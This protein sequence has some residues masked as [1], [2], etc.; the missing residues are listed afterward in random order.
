[1]SG[2]L[3]F[4]TG[5]AHITV[6]HTKPLPVHA[7]L[8]VPLAAAC[9]RRPR[10]ATCRGAARRTKPYPLHSFPL[11][12]ALHE[13]PPVCPHR[14]AP[15]K[16]HRSPPALNFPPPCPISPHTAPCSAPPRPFTS[17]PSRSPEHRRI[18]VKLKWPPPSSL[19]IGELHLPV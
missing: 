3:S 5:S 19:P 18:R 15:F 12:G 14:C 6:H 1:V 16:I 2:P 13:P 17:C 11:R 9:T 4:L 7:P 8:T 10:A